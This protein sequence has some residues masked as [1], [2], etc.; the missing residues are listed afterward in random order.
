MVQLLTDFAGGG[1][2]SSSMMNG[3]PAALKPLKSTSS[4]SGPPSDVGGASDCP[5]M[6]VYKDG[7]HYIH[8]PTQFLSHYSTNATIAR[9]TLQLRIHVITLLAQI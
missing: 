2:S 9:L 5:A 3:Q 6:I 1:I 7:V 8:T 4:L